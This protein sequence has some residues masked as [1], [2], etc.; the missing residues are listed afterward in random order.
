M[1]VGDKN[2]VSFLSSAESE[3]YCLELLLIQKFQVTASQ[4]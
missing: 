2:A 1:T 3:K 4:T